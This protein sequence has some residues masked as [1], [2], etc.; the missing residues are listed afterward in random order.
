MGSYNIGKSEI[1]AWLKKRFAKGSTCLDV[2][3]CDG[4]WW[5]LLGEHF[6]MDGI[7]IFE[8]NVELHRLEQ[9]Y[10]HV[11]VGDI[12][13]YEYDYYDLIIFG[14]VLEHMTVE[15]AQKCLLYA[16]EH[17][18]EAIIAIPYMFTQGK[19][20]GN[21]WEVHIQ[22]DLTPEVF[23]QRYPWCKL[24]LRAGNDYAYYWMKGTEKNG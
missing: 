16:Q 3:A 20:Y 19:A 14:D 21:P 9:K 2:G 4:K 11:V 17:C 15:R 22:P 23:A 5:T 6:Q 10:N 8:D 7:E 18:R 1:V 24:I 12:Y 13:D